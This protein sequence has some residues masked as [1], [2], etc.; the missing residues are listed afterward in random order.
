MFGNG[1]NQIANPDL[2]PEQSYNVNLRAYTGL[3]H[4]GHHLFIEG[5]AFYRD[6]KDFIHSALYLSNAQVSQYQNTSKVKITGVE[7]EIRYN[8]LQRL[9]AF[10]NG[11]YQRAVNNTK[12]PLGSTSGTP[13]A[14]YLNKIPNQPWF[15][16]NAGVHYT[17][18]GLLNPHQ[19]LQ[20]SWDMQ[21][22]HWF[23]LTWE[24]YGD[25]ESKS[26]IPPQ[27]IQNI[28]VSYSLKDGR[29]SIGAECR[30][31][32]DALAYDDF[33]LQKPGT[34]FSLKLHY[35]FAK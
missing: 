7:G 32:T 2:K 35:F 8:Y 18:H 1:F 4:K 14:T 5:S 21:Y 20:L 28:A 3:L 17:F 11:S 24:A 13:E 27:D 12:Y 34:S 33:R 30:N 9:G 15:F 25:L 23:Y 31:F 29:Y 26:R 19:D 16:G 6:A 22:V 10:L